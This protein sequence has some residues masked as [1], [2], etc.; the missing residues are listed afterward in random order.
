MKTI[1][2]NSQ[3]TLRQ[4]MDSELQKNPRVVGF[5][6]RFERN[7]EQNTWSI[8]SEEFEFDLP[9]HDPQT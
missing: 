1:Y 2:T 6:L 8:H 5:S 3:S 9:I 7:R 4:V